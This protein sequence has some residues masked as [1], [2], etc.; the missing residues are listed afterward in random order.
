MQHP[1]IRNINSYNLPEQKIIDLTVGNLRKYVPKNKLS[2]TILIYITSQ[3]LDP[4][5]LLLQTEIFFR[6]DVNNDG[7]ISKDD[8]IQELV[9]SS[10][11]EN[12]E[13]EAKSIIRKVDTGNY[14]YVT[15]TEFLKAVLNIDFLAS[16]FNIL[17]AFDMFDQEGDGKITAN[18]LKI[19]LQADE[20]VSDNVWIEMISSADI[21]GG[22][23]L[24][25]NEF[26]LLFRN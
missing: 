16:D 12:A 14:G 6:L 22:G 18:E 17:S 11:M 2:E 9:K 13:L 1:F 15:Y 21:D 20:R 10:S 4:L 7:K 8:L 19:A 25:L 23:I 3:L 24:D 26:K 5:D